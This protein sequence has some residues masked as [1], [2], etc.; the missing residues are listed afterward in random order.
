[1]LR[2][3]LVG[4]LRPLST[5]ED[6]EGPAL[7]RSCWDANEESVA[8]DGTAA[9]ESNERGR[10]REVN[11]SA[12]V[13]ARAAREGNDGRGDADRGGS[14][15]S[16]FPGGFRASSDSPFAVSASEAGCS[17]GGTGGGG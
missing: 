10:G 11:G 14:A 5:A 7:G 4:V 9:A 2:E 16:G 17:G 13:L 12:K 15:I 6:V 3:D 8:G 1:M